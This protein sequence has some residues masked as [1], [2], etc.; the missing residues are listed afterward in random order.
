[1]TLLSARSLWLA[2]AACAIVATADARELD[3]FESLE[4]WK[5]GASD[6][7]KGSIAS[8]AGFR[9]RAL[10]LDFDFSGVS[11]YAVARRA[12]P[13]DFPPNFELSFYVRGTAPVNNLEFKLIDAS[14]ENVWWARRADFEVPRD[15]Q[16]IRIKR[17]DI[18]FAWGPT[19]DR[20]LS[21]TA[22]LELA[23][24]AGRDGGRG[25][26]WFD[27]LQ[28]RELP[29]PSLAPPQPVIE[30][31]SAAVRIDLGGVREFG[32]LVLHWASGAHARRYDVEFS[33]DGG[34]WGRV[35]AVEGADGGTDYLRLP[36]SE[37]R[38]V[39]LK[40]LDGPG[41]TYALSEI[42]V[43]DLAFGATAN[44]FL[45]HV[46]RGAARGHYP[47]GFMGE[48]SYWTVVGVDGGHDEGLLSEDGAL[49]VAKRGFS[50]EPFVLTDDKL[51][52][53]ADVKIDHAL[54]DGY[55]PIPSVTWQHDRFSLTITAFASGTPEASQLIA[56]YDVHNPLDS[57]QTLTLALAARPFQVN[58]PTQFLNTPGGVSPIHTLAA[59]ANTVTVNGDRSVRAL[60]APDAFH[61][62]SFDAASIA[63][64]V[65]EPLACPREGLSDPTGF[66]SGA[67]LYRLQLAPRETKTLGLVVPWSGRVDTPALDAELRSVADSWRAKLNRVSIQVPP[68]GTRLVDTL[69]TSLAHVLI[70]RDG[71]ALQPGARAYER[72]WIRDGAL[73]SAALLRLGHEDVVTDYARWYARHLFPNGKVPCCVD[74]R[75][76]DPVPE[77]DSHGE[78]IFL[79]AET[80][81]YTHDRAL[82]AELWPR[83][84]AAAR[85]M[86]QLRRSERVDAN[87]TDAR[88]AYYGLMPPSISHEGY[89]D[90]PAYSYWDDFWALKGYEDAVE[91]ATTLGR[92]AEAAALA[93]SRDEFR[94]DLYASLVAATAAHG[95]DYIPGAADRGDFDATSTTIAL[96]P[97]GE[98]GR[99][100]EP[101]VR[102]TFERYWQEFVARR[103]GTKPWDAYTPYEWRTV[104][105]FVRL[106]WHARA[107][108]L[109]EFFMSSRRPAA[110]NQ[111][112]EVVGRDP[113]EPRFL[114][115]M[116]H[117]WV[118]SD[119]IRSVL[120]LF[121]YERPADAALVLAAGIPREWIEGRGVTVQDLRTP[122]GPLTYTLTREAGRVR[123]RIEEGLTLPAGGLVFK[124][125][126]RELRIRRLPADVVVKERT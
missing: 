38:Y 89:S 55:L 11:G 65:T 80:Y 112:A 79:V 123:L 125:S 2:A 122:Y 42:E 18:Q 53:W 121:A 83:V 95:I 17:R 120:D 113:R 8:D 40:L 99:L 105:A 45:E 60:V 29:V 58:P 28:I 15:W 51:V 5:A 126:G 71:P 68:A 14:G 46:A 69:R 16:R 6:S 75:G 39:R 102:A 108:E 32:G 48:Q 35:R 10:R 56:R 9:G 67:L 27:E 66:A 30:T 52:S 37:T 72:S 12:L 31:S 34:T 25:S 90:R 20:Q 104:G 97:V 59:Q 1:M 57:P 70:N 4:P 47:R 44:A 85:Y 23:V 22:T 116:P 24:S 26:V 118:A 94:N 76:A 7:V 78:L 107:H 109:L 63:A 119:F 64:L 88:R 106:G 115:D 101:L 98:L 93:S 61:C 74:R 49:E 87:R 86:D 103:D 33:Q 100:P 124:W 92:R 114:G 43:R 41:R 3:S 84:E 13:L 96:D 50:I 73:T 91:I 21:R 54:L 19:S 82:L 77:N 111:W 36:D 117:G 81:R 110:W 62:A